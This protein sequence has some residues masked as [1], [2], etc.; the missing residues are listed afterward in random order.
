[1][2]STATAKNFTL[3]H[4]PLTPLDPQEPPTAASIRLLCQELYA[5]AQS[6][7][8][9]LG[10]GGHGH[11]GMLMPDP[12][13]TQLSL[14]GAAYILPNKPP[15]P[16]YAGTA[17]QR[18]QQKEDYKAETEAYNEARYLQHQLQQQ[19]LQAVPKIY[20]AELA[21]SKVG[22]AEVTPT[23]ILTLL[24]DTYGTI[25]PTDLEENLERIKTLWNPDTPIQTVFAN[26]TTCRQFATDG[27][28]PIPDSA[29]IR[30]LLNIFG[31]SGV[32]A[33]SIRDWEKKPAAE[34][35][36]ANAT[37]HFI[38]D[39]KIR[40]Q[41]KSYMKDIL[42]ASP[43]AQANAVTLPPR[44]D[45]QN[46]VPQPPD[47]T[48]SGFFYCWTHGIVTHTGASCKSPAKG[49]VP[50]ATVTNRQGGSTKLILGRHR[51][52]PDR[53]STKRKASG[54]QDSRQQGSRS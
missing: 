23:A 30:I 28:E 43:A 11:L 7:E 44:P 46:P 40:L 4:D 45:P 34:H 25:T 18:D 51:D 39:N 2:A 47:G 54:K 42:S 53:E 16:I 3:P 50:N 33:D 6:V 8:S 12:E 27:N 14:N 48:M 17:T 49:H 38:R 35:T 13:Y 52:K 29:Y 5:N 32:L 37:K 1:M 31:Q 15:V 26:G 36:V 22:Y 24:V 20:I 19:L 10:G 21:S 41:S 9:K